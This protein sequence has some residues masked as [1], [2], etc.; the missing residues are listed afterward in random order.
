MVKKQW[1]VAEGNC[2]CDQYSTRDPSTS[3]S[4]SSSSVGEVRGVDARPS[5]VSAHKE[6][7]EVRK[8]LLRCDIQEFPL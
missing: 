4:T 8:A 7:D 5:L 1:V 6:S 2:C 3:S